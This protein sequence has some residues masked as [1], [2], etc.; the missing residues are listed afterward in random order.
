MNYPQ[1]IHMS[2]DISLNTFLFLKT[3]PQIWIIPERDKLIVHRKSASI[4]PIF[5]VVA[6]RPYKALTMRL[7]H[8]ACSMNSKPTLV[9]TFLIILALVHTLLI[10]L[11][12]MHK[13]WNFALMSKYCT[14]IPFTL[15]EHFKRPSGL[16]LL[17]SHTKEF[18]LP[19]YSFMA[20]TK[21]KGAY[22]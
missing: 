15:V 20:Y 8:P 21:C 5:L 6:V 12:R 1:I 3:H 13:P 4:I 9:Q 17:S 14:E 7:I 19:R 11:I 18:L 22:W 10:C 2:I 16:V